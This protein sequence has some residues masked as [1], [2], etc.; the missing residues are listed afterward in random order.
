VYVCTSHEVHTPTY[1]PTT[2]VLIIILFEHNKK[3]PTLIGMVQYRT[4]PYPEET[5]M[6]VFF[7]LSYHYNIF[8]MH[9]QSFQK[10]R[11]ITPIIF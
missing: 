3:A 2:Y 6:R 5:K 8:E 4:I 11:I 7:S 9:T 1:V 10:G